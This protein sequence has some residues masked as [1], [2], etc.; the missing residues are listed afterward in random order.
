MLRMR[1][2]RLAVPEDFWTVASEIPDKVRSGP[3]EN[4]SI[5][6]RAPHEIILRYRTIRQITTCQ[7]LPDD[8]IVNTTIP[9]MSQYAIRI[10]QRGDTYL[11]IID[12]PQGSKVIASVLN[13]ILAEKRYSF[14]PLEINLPMIERH[15]AAFDA[16]RL[17][18][19]K[20]KDFQVYE[21]AVGRLEIA[22]KS[23]LKPEIA[24]FIGNK[25]HRIESL[26]YEITHG[27]VQGLVQYSSSGTVKVSSQL[28]EKAFPLFELGLERRAFKP[29]N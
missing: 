10:F 11:S 27:F 29:S 3:T 22:S 21:G 7:I 18:S 5:S 1:Y 17:V 23:G 19:A 25:F 9:T 13:D 2:F 6:Q 12:P 8:S 24:P 15:V 26:T 20:V 16:A 14:E 4:I 28:V